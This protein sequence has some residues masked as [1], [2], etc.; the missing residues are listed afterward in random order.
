MIAL[1]GV[2]RAG[3]EKIEKTKRRGAYFIYSLKTIFRG[4]G[5]YLYW[6]CFV[7]GLSGK[8]PQRKK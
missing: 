3:I 7:W 2:T 6:C 8:I 4:V 1:L 5:G